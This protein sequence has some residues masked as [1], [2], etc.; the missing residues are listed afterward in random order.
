MA[1]EDHLIPF[2]EDYY[3][4]QVE[5]SPRD[6]EDYYE[7]RKEDLADPA[8]YNIR[9]ILVSSMGAASRAHR[10][11]ALGADFAQLAMEVS[12][13]ERTAPSGGDMGWMSVG[14]FA[15]YDSL[16]ADMEPGDFS[17]PFETYSGLEIIKLEARR[18][19]RIPSLEEA[20]PDIRMYI[21]NTRTNEMLAEFFNRKR[22]EVG[23]TLNE[24]ILRS[25]PLPEPD[26]AP[27]EYDEAAPVEEQPPPVLPKI[28]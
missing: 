3:K 24:E 4:S 16:V 19:P 17:A 6:I 14:M 22:E 26:Y 7:A 12:E 11:L 18:A 2:M 10:R 27:V 23:F 8:A 21:T 15:T 5:I 28:G 1:R 25:V 9:R 13:D 20:T